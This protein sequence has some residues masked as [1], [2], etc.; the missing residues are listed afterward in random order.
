MRLKLLTGCL[1]VVG[2]FCSV[3]AGIAEAPL[4]ARTPSG[5]R[6]YCDGAKPAAAAPCPRGGAP[7]QVW[8]ALALQTIDPGTPCPVSE[9]RT[10]TPRAAPVLG[11]GP[12]YVTP[13]AYN[14]ADRSTMRVPYPAPLTSPAAGTGWTLAKAPILMPRTLRQ[15]IVLRGRQ[16]DGPGILG[17]S[18]YAGRRPFSA[19][20][21]PPTGYTINLGE[22]KAHSLYIWANTPGCYGIQIDGRTF[23]RVAI[24]RVEFFA[25]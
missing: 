21:F 22:Y 1:V 18:G 11:P 8:R 14:L 5:Y 20:Q 24:F 4:P 12:V 13:G 6:D 17:F 2:L 25:S 10:I 9:S 16:L 19:M 7:T 3:A 15:P 23:S